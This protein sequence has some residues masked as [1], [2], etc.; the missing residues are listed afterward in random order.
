MKMEREVIEVGCQFFYAGCYV[1]RVSRGS[2]MERE[3]GGEEKGSEIV[4]IVKIWV[5]V[6][7]NAVFSLMEKQIQSC[8][9]ALQY[10]RY[11]RIVSYSPWAYSRFLKKYRFLDSLKK[12]PP[13]KDH[14]SYNLGLSLKLVPGKSLLAVPY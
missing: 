5:Y 10:T 8:L 14:S 11:T 3:R 13:S 1:W 12:Q 4:E 9:L 6:F 7:F 2:L